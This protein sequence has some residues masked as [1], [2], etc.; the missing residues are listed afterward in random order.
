MLKPANI[1]H[2]LNDRLHTLPIRRFVTL[3]N[4]LHAALMIAILSATVT[5]FYLVKFT[6][7]VDQ[8]LNGGDFQ[9]SATIYAAYPADQQETRARAV[10]FQ[11]A[12]NVPTAITSYFDASR[13]RQQTVKFQEIPRNLLKAV[14]S[15]EDRTFFTHHG[16]NLKRIAG[17]LV[18]NVK[19]GELAEGG[20]TLTQQLARSLFLNREPTLQRKVAEAIIAVILERRLTKEQIFTMY[21]NEIYLG[22]RD[23]F[24]I[25]GFAEAAKAYFG[26]ELSDITLAEA[27]TLAG[28]IPAPNAYSPVQH[29]DRAEARRNLILKIMA[30]SGKI[31]RR[32]YEEARHADLKIAASLDPAEGHYLVDYIRGELLKD[33]QEE[34]LMTGGL[35]VYTTV[36]LGLQ[37]AAMDSVEYGLTLVEAQLT[38][39]SRGQ[40]QSQPG[41]QAG[42]IALD[43]RTGEIKAMVGGDHYGSTQ[44]NR[45]T[46]ALRQPGSIFKPFVYAAALETALEGLKVYGLDPEDVQSAALI[47]PV[48]MLIDEPMVFSGAKEDYAPKNY[49]G[50]Y[51]GEVTLREAFYHSLNVPT[52]LLAQRIGFDRVASLARRMG[53]NPNV[54]GYP[55]L[56]LGTVEVTPLEIA[57]AYT[58][59]ANEGQRVEPHALRKVVSPDGNVL[60]TYTPKPEEVLNPQVAY[61]MTHLMEGVLNYGTGAGVRARG[62]NLPAA[63]KTG[64]S[65]DGWFA[66][67]TKDLLVI[68]WVGFDDGQDLNLEGAK[69]A[70]PIWADFMKK[71]YQ[72]RPTRSVDSMYFEPPR[73]IELVRIDAATLLRGDPACGD[74]FEEAFIEGTAPTESCLD[75]A[76]E[77][78]LRVSS[79]R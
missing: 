27:A 73:G 46:Q 68:A 78:D 49:G 57:G 7:M 13:T 55:S 77:T 22:H 31:T 36:D 18:S 24:A 51:R 32:A 16:L 6:T 19:Q 1:L 2:T 42:L 5:L 44:Y 66:G 38:K 60:R 30:D 21:A 17:A 10:S 39:R 63:G 14:L 65:R 54:R 29:P 20:S 72:L 26:K 52:V 43:P 47:S 62:F 76:V 50:Q 35:A 4:L 58:A 59:F 23:S 67:Y 56:A 53:L 25:H 37:Q 69:S 9:R 79:H 15:G 74:S 61:L 40:N 75:F 71:A 41:P 45:I 12:G 64:T 48:T 34:N 8:R 33:F 3:K 11:S 28:V 70:L